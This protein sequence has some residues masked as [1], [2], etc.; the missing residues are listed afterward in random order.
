MLKS[1]L[2]NNTFDV[3]VRRFFDTDATTLVSGRLELFRQCTMDKSKPNFSFSSLTLSG[4]IKSTR[5]E[6]KK[7]S[8]KII[9]IL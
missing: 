2:T 4:D 8:Y 5:K 9:D 7:L 3:V 6:Y 1:D